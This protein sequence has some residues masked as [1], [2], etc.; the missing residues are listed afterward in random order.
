MTAD[1]AED[2]P[3]PLSSAVPLGTPDVS[4]QHHR[5]ENLRTP[6]HSEAPLTTPRLQLPPQTCNPEERLELRLVYATPRISQSSIVTGSSHL[7]GLL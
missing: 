1:Q 2:S 4:T 3:P 6:V 5:T 7:R